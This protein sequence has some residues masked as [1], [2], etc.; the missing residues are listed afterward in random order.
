MKKRKNG[1]RRKKRE[2]EILT[3]WKNE[4]KTRYLLKSNLKSS[5]GK[6]QTDWRKT[7]SETS[8]REKK[9]KTNQLMKVELINFL[10]TSFWKRKKLTY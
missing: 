2:E 1:K 10:R 7:N 9:K 6:K 4:N 3:N 5:K 8:S